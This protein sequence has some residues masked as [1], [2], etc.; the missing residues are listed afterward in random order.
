MRECVIRPAKVED[1]PAVAAIYEHFV[2]ESVA[3]F[4]VIAPD[5]AEMTRRLKAVQERGLPYL[6][7]T[8]EKYVVGY[9]YASQFRPREAYRLTVEDSIYV[10]ADCIGYG[11]GKRLLTQLIAGCHEAGCH[12]MVACICGDNPASV[13]LHRSLGFE[14][15]GLLPEAGLKF[16]QWVDMAMMQR[17]L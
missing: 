13:A 2:Q 10:R 12:R 14:P 1:M 17:S 6:V 8:L 5:T 3:T 15:A 9:C 16:E 7:A 4:E 11:V